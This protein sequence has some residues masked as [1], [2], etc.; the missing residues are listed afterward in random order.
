MFV[1]FRPVEVSSKRPPN[2]SKLASQKVV[3]R[4]PR[5]DDLS[6]EF[7]EQLFKRSYK[8]IDKLKAKEFKVSVV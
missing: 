1:L 8:F 6:G 5:F 3:T 4:D 7:N 2:L